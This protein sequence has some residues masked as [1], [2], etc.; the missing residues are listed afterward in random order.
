MTIFSRISDMKASRHLKKPKFEDKYLL[1]ERLGSGSFAS[2][3][4]CKLKL[5]EADGPSPQM[6]P[7][8]AVKV[9]DKSNTCSIFRVESEIWSLVAPHENCVRMLEAF[10]DD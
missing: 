7:P 2:V 1:D 8:L 3:Y 10:E 9:F 6:K 5:A 4:Q